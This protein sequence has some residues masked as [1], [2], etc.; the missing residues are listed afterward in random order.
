MPLQKEYGARL[1][2]GDGLWL[3]GDEAVYYTVE[4]VDERGVYLHLEEREALYDV[5]GD[6][7]FGPIESPYQLPAMREMNA[8]M[9]TR[10]P[11]AVEVEHKDDASGPGEMVIELY[12]KDGDGYIKRSTDDDLDALMADA[13]ETLLRLQIKTLESTAE[14]GDLWIKYLKYKK[15]R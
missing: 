9:P 6:R 2:P 15:G 11:L 8:L 13:F 10:R 14:I 12:A 3:L 4:D 5:F 1:K 7:E